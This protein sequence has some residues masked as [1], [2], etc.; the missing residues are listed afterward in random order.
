M[1][2]GIHKPLEDLPE[3]PGKKLLMA[4]A[5]RRGGAPTEDE[6]KEFQGSSRSHKLLFSKI[7]SNDP[8]FMGEIITFKAGDH[9]KC[10]RCDTDID[11]RGEE[12]NVIVC[13]TCKTNLTSVENNTS[14]LL[15]E[16]DILPLPW[17]CVDALWQKN[18]N[19][20]IKGDIRY[21]IPQKYRNNEYYFY[22]KKT[23]K[24]YWEV[25]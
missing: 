8:I 17:I 15:Q 9:I 24:S 3:G 19:L 21:D 5:A 22:N 2:G 18:T 25:D 16:C 10:A 1:K 6:L 12:E 14:D 23:G 11:Y 7:C 13:P 4:I 20:S